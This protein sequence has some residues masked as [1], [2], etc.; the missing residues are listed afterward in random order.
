MLRKHTHTYTDELAKGWNRLAKEKGL[1]IGAREGG[2]T[3]REC[4]EM[5]WG[6]RRRQKSGGR[7][8][9]ATKI[10]IHVGKMGR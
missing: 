9:E 1:H 10:P 7:F 6:G 3:Q 5:H 4:G 8:M 2:V